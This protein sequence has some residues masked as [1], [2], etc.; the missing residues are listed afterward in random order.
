M[1]EL[2]FSNRQ[3]LERRSCMKDSERVI[4]IEIILQKVED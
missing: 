4:I 2:R 1:E 3:D